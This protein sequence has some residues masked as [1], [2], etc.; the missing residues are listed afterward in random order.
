MSEVLAVIVGCAVG[1]A[2]VRATGPVLFGGRR[3][4]RTFT[5]LVAALSP[6]LLA[7]LVVTQA[8]ADGPRLAAGADTAGVAAGGLVAVATASPVAAVVVAAAVTALL[9]ATGTL[10]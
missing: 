5:V 2:V 1:S 8:L 6:A 9:R 4:P 3:M 10:A 7:A